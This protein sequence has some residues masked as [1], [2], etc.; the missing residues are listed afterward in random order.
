V[1]AWGM[2]L[3]RMAYRVAGSRR[4]IAVE[5]LAHAFPQL[6]PTECERIA[7]ATFEHFGRML[8]EVIR[9]G[10]LSHDEIRA[11]CDVDGEQ[12]VLSSYAAGN[13]IIFLAAHLGFWEMQGISNPL[14]WRPISVV[15]RPLDNPWLHARLEHIRTRTGN[16]VIYRQGSVRRVL[17]ALGANRG[18]AILIDQHLNAQD[19]LRV[20]FFGRPA[21]TTA[22]VASLVLR[23]G[24]A[25][26]P[27]FG[28]P[29]PGGRYRMVYGRPV[30]PPSDDSPAAVLD[31]TQRCTNVI[32]ACVR[33]HPELWL[34][35][36]RR[37]RESPAV[38]ETAETEGATAASASKGNL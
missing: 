32:E 9:F 15:A 23:T 1:R 16:E 37:W 33:E 18:V 5:N 29:L 34:W 28:L 20:N 3:G 12:H 22:I 13:G 4:R 10:T 24:A 11:L 14:S 8:L 36:H 31:F 38:S 35:M 27:A 25:V 7:R 19:A 2:A 30:E 26:V 21:A 6:S 17:R